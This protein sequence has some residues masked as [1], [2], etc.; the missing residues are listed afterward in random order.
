MAVAEFLT[1]SSLIS[2]LEYNGDTYISVHNAT[3]AKNLFAGN[4]SNVGQ[5]YVD[6]TY[7]I[8]RFAV[9]WDTS[10]LDDAAM[11][12]SAYMTFVVT[13]ESYPLTVIVK[14]G[15]PDYPT[16]PTPIKADYNIANY[17]GNGGGGTVGD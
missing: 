16:I 13:N 10:D 9:G 14:D 11:I 15:T 6:S 17:S 3:E 1:N 7:Y 5:A 2:D 8:R 4:D 12:K